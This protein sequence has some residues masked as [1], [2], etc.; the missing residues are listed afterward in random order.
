MPS[1]PSDP[2]S[3]TD[4]RAWRAALA[5]L[6]LAGAVLAVPATRWA[7]SAQRPAVLPTP[8]PPAA[9]VAA[10]AAAGIDAAV[11]QVQLWQPLR[12]APPPVAE[13]PPPPP[14]E[15]TLFAISQSGTQPRATFDHPEQ[16]LFHLR[17]GE[18]AH[19]LMLER[20]EGR[21]AHVRWQGEPR[22][23]EFGHE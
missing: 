15:F 14:L 6:L 18:T 13:R 8:P 21:R 19:G 1:L 20:I 17:P 23:L 16:G 2:W 5:G 7:L 10:T 9:P 3:R 22:V 4:R 11:W 12:D